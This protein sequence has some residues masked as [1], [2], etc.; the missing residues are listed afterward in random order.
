MYRDN[1]LPF[2]L[3]LK[4]AKKGNKSAFGEIYELWAERVFRFCLKNVGDREVASDLTSEIFLK[5]WQ[6]LPDFVGDGRS[7]SA[8]TYRIAKNAANDY[9]RKSKVDSISIEDA[10]EIPANEDP[11]EC[12]DTAF[13]SKLEGALQ[14][15]S[16]EFRRAIELRYIKGLTFGQMARHLHKKEGT[17]RTLISRALRALRS[18]LAK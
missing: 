12:F 18:R 9:F 3:L 4:Q 10:P 13:D 1:S 17:V 2:D 15:L 7:F 14:S 5:I 8:W 6:N 16:D 11:F